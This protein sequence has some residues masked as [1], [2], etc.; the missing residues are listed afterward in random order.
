MV[1]KPTSVG[2]KLDSDSLKPPSPKSHCHGC[3]LDLHSDD[4]FSDHSLDGED[5]AGG[6]LLIDS[7]HLNCLILG[8]TKNY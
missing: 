8:I 7:V 3:R 5:E 6:S 1:G 2:Q 4:W